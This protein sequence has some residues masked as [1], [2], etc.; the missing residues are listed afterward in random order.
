M[1]L[2]I[3]CVL[4]A[5]CM[6]ST[7][8]LG[9]S[10]CT[11]EELAPFLEEYIAPKET[12]GEFVST[13][14]IEE[15]SEPDTDEPNTL[16]GEDTVAPDCSHRYGEWKIAKEAGCEEEG[17]QYRLCGVCNGRQED[18]IPPTG[19]TEED[20]KPV[21]ATCVLAGREGGTRCAVCKKVLTSPDVLLANGHPSYSNGYCTVCSIPLD[22]ADGLS[23]LDVYN[24]SYGYEYLGTM[25]KGDARQ[26]LYRE[27]DEAVKIFHTDPSAE[28]DK[29]S[30]SHV[31]CSPDYATLGLTA[32]EAQAVW[33]TYRDDHPLYYWMSNRVGTAGKKIYLLAF[34]EYVDGETRM[35]TNQLVYQGIAEYLSEVYEGST[36]YEVAL[37]VHDALIRNIDYAYDENGNAEESDWAHSILGI[38]DGRGAVCEGIAKA[39]QLLLNFYDVD[40]LLV[41]GFTEKLDETTGEPKKI[42]HAWNVICLDGAWYG[43]DVT[44]DENYTESESYNAAQG[45]P[46]KFFCLSATE[47]AKGRNTD[48]FENS[49]VEFLY[50]LPALSEYG[51]EWV[52]LYLSGELIGRYTSMDSAF[53]AM[54]DTDG[55][56]HIKLYDGTDGLG[57]HRAEKY[58]IV[59]D[60]P[61]VYTLFIE[62][63]VKLN[64]RTVTDISR[65]Y[66]SHDTELKSSVTMKKVI[67]TAEELIRLKTGSHTL[68]YRWDNVYYSKK[69]NIVLV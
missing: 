23:Y 46:Y 20:M 29:I 44:W 52:D 37:L 53:A 57:Y 2:R 41:T 67:L 7:C 63:I 21:P 50:R 24:Q 16:P 68:T 51:V 34:D 32:E 54:N 25:E 43:V 69:E 47:F 17:L 59:G 45:I 10:S 62:G 11:I 12:E 6:L 40:C 38:F 48:S 18:A 27:F 33:K 36:D 4:T 61:Q 14:E 8:V 66:L 60:F 39:Y 65:I 26:T 1:K 19:H 15:P 35:E 58:H 31:V 30:D 5:F 28:T 64:G 13:V 42:G 49:S 9:L 3:F 55:K 56:Y 22:G